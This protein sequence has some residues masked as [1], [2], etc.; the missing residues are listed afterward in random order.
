MRAQP[1]CEEEV[2][3]RERERTASERRQRNA[4]AI[5]EVVGREPVQTF[6]MH[7]PIFKRLRDRDMSNN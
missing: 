1:D 2:I 3:R 5:A 6:Q 7:A 4:Q